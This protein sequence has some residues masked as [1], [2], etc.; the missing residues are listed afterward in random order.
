MK[1]YWRMKRR[2]SFCCTLVF[3]AML[4]W[5]PL[6]VHAEEIR[7][8]CEIY[9]THAT[10]C[11]GVVYYTI[12]ADLSSK[13]STVD[14]DQCDLCGGYHDY[15]EYTASCSCGKTWNTTGHAC[16]NSPYGTNGGNCSNYS[17]VDASTTHLHPV[18]EYICGKTEETVIEIITI[19]K[20]TLLPAKQVVVTAVASGELENVR[21]AWESE[22]E[23]S[24]N[25]EKQENAV[26]TVKEN[27]TYGL[28]VIYVD[29]GMEYAMETEVVVDNVDYTEPLAK[30][31]FNQTEFTAGSVILSVVASDEGGLPVEYIS[32]NGEAFG[33][34]SQYEITENGTYE[35]II[36]DI[37]GNTFI[38]SITVDNIDNVPPEI[39]SLKSEPIPWYSGECTVSVSAMDAGDGNAGSGLAEMAYSWDGGA[40]WTNHA[41]FTLFEPDEVVVLVRDAV[42]NISTERLNVERQELP[43]ASEPE[44]PEK[45]TSESKESN[46]EEV[47]K[48]PISESENKTEEELEEEAEE[49][50]DETEYEEAEV[51]VSG[52]EVV[53]EEI[54]FQEANLQAEEAFLSKPDLQEEKVIL[55]E[56]NHQE[57]EVVLAESEIREDDEI[58]SNMELLPGVMAESNSDNVFTAPVAETEN[59]KVHKTLVIVCA[60]AIMVGG[61]GFVTAGLIAHILFGMCKVYEVGN[62]QKEAYL[63][64]VGIR[65]YKKGYKIIIGTDIVDQATGR[66]LKIKIPSWLVRFK[67][68]KLLQIVVGEEVI[69]KYIEQNIDIHINM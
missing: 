64:N 45:E 62:Q 12:S 5:I 68:F 67:E 7:Y 49:S 20:S 57:E 31:L 1:K 55:P 27:G 58:Q 44:I 16:I 34:S 24:E 66:N 18:T 23:T 29:A 22:A 19:E 10:D 4:L 53:V 15:Y 26:L 59:R 11:Q 63:G 36:R 21:L 47:T 50:G 51:P 46:T 8:V 33:D 2:F 60:S 30:F 9:H 39:I 17:A 61:V 42:G 56:Q 6:L 35:I 37:A 13:L 52:Q 3:V 25:N 43:E 38:K 32:W 28:S 40:S 41:T 69:D 14:T 54:I 65:P 48:E